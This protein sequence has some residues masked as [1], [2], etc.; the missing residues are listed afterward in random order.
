MTLGDNVVMVLKLSIF[1]V[2]S[3]AFHFHNPSRKN[4]C[5]A[6]WSKIYLYFLLPQIAR[7]LRFYPPT[8]AS[9]FILR[10]LSRW[11]SQYNEQKPPQ[12]IKTDTSIDFIRNRTWSWMNRHKN[13]WSH[14]L[15]A[16]FKS[17]MKSWRNLSNTKRPKNLSKEKSRKR[18]F[19]LF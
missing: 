3:E 18:L 16:I 7:D 12:N 13:L 4:E 1:R 2:F 10:T 8:Y 14:P 19:Y 9:L 11:V 17:K 5:N 6:L 15:K